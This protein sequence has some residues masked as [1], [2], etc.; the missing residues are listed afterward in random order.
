M[1]EPLTPHPFARYIPSQA[2]LRLFEASVVLAT[3]VGTGVYGLIE[4]AT[5]KNDPLTVRGTSISLSDGR[6]FRLLDVDG[7]G[8]LDKV[9]NDAG[10][11]EQLPAEEWRELK[12]KLSATYN[13]SASELNK[14]LK[15]F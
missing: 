6:E 2:K 1:D 10:M 8:T 12:T 11:K 9:V 5:H 14:L 15:G 7:N 13:I 3:M 4:Y